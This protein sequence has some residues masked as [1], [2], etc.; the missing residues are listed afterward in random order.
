MADGVDVFLVSSRSDTGA[1]D[2]RIKT[3][4]SE[5]FIPIHPRLV[6]FGFLD[7]VAERRRQG[8]TKLFPELTRS[9]T[10]YYSDPY[11]KWFRRFLDKAGAARP[12]TCFHSFRHC[13]R[14]ALREARIDHDVALALGGWSSGNGKEGTETA[15][16]YG[17]GFRVTTLWEALERVDYPNLDLTHLLPNDGPPR[18]PE[19]N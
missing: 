9:S 10:G 8:G 6:K 5:R 18:H 1:D 16:V 13:F 12:K 15:E 2:K 7:F 3:A 19:S 11:S 17:R 4:T 14:D